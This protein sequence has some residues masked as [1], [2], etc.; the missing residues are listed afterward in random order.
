MNISFFFIFYKK[1]NYILYKFKKI[2]R[3]Y[4]SKH[5]SSNLIFFIYK[6]SPDKNIK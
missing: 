2:H 5:K 4:F 1:K 6:C 3:L